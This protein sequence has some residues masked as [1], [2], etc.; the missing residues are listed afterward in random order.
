MPN[1]AGARY[2]EGFKAEAV[3]LARS[4]PKKST[5]QNSPMSL[6]SQTRPYAIGSSEQRSPAA[7]E[8][9]QPPKSAGS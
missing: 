4:S 6:T 3:Q 1:S 7:S 2:T 5:R 9:A 8:R